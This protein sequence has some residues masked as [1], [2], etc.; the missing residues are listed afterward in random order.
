MKGTLYVVAT[1]IGNL[2]DITLRAL[3]VLKEVDVIA[4]EDTRHTRKLLSH[5]GISRPLMS[6]WGAR[7]KVRAE[8]VISTLRDGRDVALVTD[9]GTPGIS[10]PGGVV[11]REAVEAGLDVVPVPGPSA[12]IAALSVSGIS[13]REFVYLGFLPNKR[14]QRIK[15][16][17]SL[18]FEERTLVFYEAPHRLLESLAD[19]LDLLGDRYT[20]VCHELTKLNEEVM[21]GRLS[22]LISELEEGTVAG[23]YVIVTEGRG[24]EEVPVEGAVEEVWALMKKGLRRKD[25]VKRVAGQYGISQK[26]LYDRSLTPAPEGSSIPSRPPGSAGADD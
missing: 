11:V 25:A 8:A 26:A 14:S 5:Y 4:A 20:A 12:V 6:Y 18:R 23:E 13:A 1:P 3:R 21:R 10:D 16:L 7:E 19:I 24:A 22:L 15:R 9:S 17:E 2:E